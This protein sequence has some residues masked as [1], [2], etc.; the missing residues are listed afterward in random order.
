ML[1][2]YLVSTLA[3]RES[4]LLPYV[5]RGCQ[6]VMAL[7]VPLFLLGL[8]AG[9]QVL[10]AG[11]MGT[12]LLLGGAL[13]LF[14]ASRVLAVKCSG[15][16]YPVRRERA[17]LVV[18]TALIALASFWAVGAYAQEK[19]RMDARYL[20]AHLTL[21]PAVVLDT[22]E[23]LYLPWPGVEEKALPTASEQRFRYRYRG[24]RLL[25]QSN[26]QMFVIGKNWTWQDGAVMIIPVDGSVRV[27]FHAG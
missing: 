1:A 16:P 10:D 4:G 17:A 19:G 26:N 23:R 9:L 21:R 18:S 15:T 12:P 7:A 11:P 6:A 3:R 2:Y 20:A 13:L 22:A 27:A 25:A 14:L 8:L 5:R 24:L